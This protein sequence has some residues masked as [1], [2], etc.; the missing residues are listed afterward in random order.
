MKHL[1]LMVKNV[2]RNPLRAVLTALGTMVLLSVV[3]LVWAVL[4]YLDAMTKAKTQNLKAIVTERWKI[5]SQMPYAYAA[6][7]CEG[8]AREPGD[9]RPVDA[10]TWQFYGGSVEADAKKRTRDDIVF[11]IACDP[12]KI[13]T[14]LD[15]LDETP[16][17][18][19]RELRAGCETLK[20]KR[21]GL[22]IG[23]TRLAAIHKRV[24]DRVTIYSMNYK[25]I[26]LEFEIVGLFPPG[27]YDN[28]A[29]M[30]RDYLNGA[31][32]AYARKPP[33]RPH[34]MADRAMNLVWL[35]VKDMDDFRRIAA[36]IMNSP[37]YKV[38][39]VKCET[40]SSGVAAFLDTFRDLLWGVRWLLA[41]ACLVTVSLIIAIAISLSVRERRTELAVLKVLGFRPGQILLLVLGESVL[42]GFFFGALGAAAT[43]MIVNYG[44]GGIR[45]PIGFL[46]S[47]MIPKAAL[48]WGPVV[49]ALTALAGSFIPAWSARNVKVAEVFSKVA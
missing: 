22:L 35:R 31:L 23:R 4:D 30:H 34:P 25:G 33:G 41:P 16:P 26:D 43:Y 42:M 37:E 8:A 24:G 21:N 17:E 40:A 19:L 32:D 29:A 18:Q 11:A 39:A 3:T 28:T 20:S 47:F 14:M 45:F 10:M 44:M 48:W 36:Q 2:V 12:D 13:C 38:P 6:S 15:D 49:G 46:S 7:L 9:V 1:L 27:R 5:P